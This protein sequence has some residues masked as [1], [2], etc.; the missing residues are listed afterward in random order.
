MFR[1]MILGLLR[2]GMA[3]HGYA[4]VKAYERRAGV[5]VRTGN[6]YRELSR[7][8]REGLIRRVDAAAGTDWRRAPYVITDRGRAELEGWLAQPASGP[9]ASATDE[10]AVRALCLF[11]GAAAPP[12][13]ALEPLR[14]ALWIRAKRLERE[15]AA[16][17]ADGE[18]PS[19]ILSL[20]LERRLAHTAV[21]LELVEK[22]AALSAADPVSMH[23]RRVDATDAIAAR[24]GR[25][26]SGR[27]SHPGSG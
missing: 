26:R 13:A 12:P 14:V 5:E 21:D 9:G 23:A 7:L 6:V 20:L 15:R 3:L 4:L 27:S 10:T 11:D 17:R 19:A 22:L 2:G 16:A 18:A 8:E 25:V 24:A 1:Y